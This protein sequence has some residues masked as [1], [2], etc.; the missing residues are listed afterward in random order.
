[1]KKILILGALFIGIVG[2]VGSMSRLEKEGVLHKNLL[3]TKI[4]QYSDKH[5]TP[6]AIVKDKKF[7]S[8]AFESVEGKSPIFSNQIAAVVRAVKSFT[9]G[10]EKDEKEYGSWIWTP[11]LQITP[12]Y[13]YSTL[14]NTI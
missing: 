4:S 2:L 9:K 13:M 14:K 8:L 7:E 11:I 3:D 12:P 5:I 1:M 10:E 6:N